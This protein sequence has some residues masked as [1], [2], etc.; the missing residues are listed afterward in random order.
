MNI[1]IALLTSPLL[2]LADEP[3]SGLDSHNAHSVM[4]GLKARH[5]LPAGR[6]ACF[7]PLLHAQEPTPRAGTGRGDVLLPP[8]AHLEQC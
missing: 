6:A 2:L 1:A 8:H 7:P 4:L 3:V 5:S